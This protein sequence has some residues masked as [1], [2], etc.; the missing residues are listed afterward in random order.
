MLS[1]AAVAVPRLAWFAAVV[2]LTGAVAEV[3]LVWLALRALDA[4]E[5]L[6]DAVA[7]PAPLD[8]AAVA[9]QLGAVVV[10]WQA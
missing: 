3:L 10:A 5:R 1:D 8:V 4:A 6:F 7:V 9:L 2:A